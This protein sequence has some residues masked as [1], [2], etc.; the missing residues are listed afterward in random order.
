ML[1]AYTG[2]SVRA[3]ESP[4]LEAGLGDELMQRAAHGLAQAAAGELSATGGTYGRSVVVLAGSGNNGGDALYAGARLQQRGTGT[5]AVLTSERVHAPALAAFCAAG[6]RVVALSDSTLD[7]AAARVSAA[8]LI[9]DGILGT[10]GV[11]G[12]RG[13]AAALIERVNAR[14]T[15]GT[16]VACDVPSGVNADTG[17]ATGHLLSADL[18][19]TFGALK[20]G[21]LIG[22]G[23]RAA[24]RVATIDIGLGETLP[25]P[26]LYSLEPADF[27]HLYA[28]PQPADHKYSRGVLGIAA[29]SAMY[30][31]AAVLATGA[32]LAT[33][34]GMIRFLGPERVTALINTVHPEVV[35][36]QGSVSDS[37]V[38]AWLVGPGAT[39]DPGQRQRAREAISSGLPTI[40]DAGAL[41]LLPDTV[42]AHVILTPHA[43]ELAALFERRGDA[44]D[45]TAIEADPAGFARRAAQATG[46]TVLLKGYT[47]V[48][49]ASTGETFVQANATPW[50][51]TAGSGDTLAGILGALVA[52]HAANATNNDAGSLPGVPPPARWA[53][54]AAAGALLHGL[55]G[56][57]AAKRGPIVVS[58]LP[59]HIGRVIHDLLQD[60]PST[61]PQ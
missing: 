36:S 53:V 16:V 21:L 29:G 6:G 10:G 47:T 61:Q 9:L 25:E 33:G 5:T 17:E 30:P 23:A 40:V 13:L 12:L 51:A 35:C 52:T 45:R 60:P 3:A 11:G 54:L 26:D 14:G 42:G 44:V 46:A 8:D 38:Q 59:R 49:A 56:R 37:H 27:R 15:V 7:S 31:G 39:E 1:S 22:A 4:L 55:A 50:L 32:A 41:P 34:V 20:S 48:V 43:G 57:R 19:I 24:G 2:S 28:Q 58:G 18:T